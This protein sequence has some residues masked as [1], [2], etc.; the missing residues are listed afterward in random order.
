[1]FVKSP[2]KENSHLSHSL[3]RDMSKRTYEDRANAI[4]VPDP[5]NLEGGSIGDD[6][7]EAFEGSELDSAADVTLP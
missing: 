6:E 1:M 3:L 5:N 7:E 4:E 2:A